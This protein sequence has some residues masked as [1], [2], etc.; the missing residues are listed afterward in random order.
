MAKYGVSVDRVVRH[1]D[2]S[3]KVCPNWSDNNWSRWSNFKN[4]LLNNT[5]ST[6]STIYRVRNANNDA[7]SQVGAFKNLDSAKNLA[8]EKGLCGL[9]DG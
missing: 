7:K 9:A 1:Y 6:S 4:K 3:R 5:T 8:K 2:A